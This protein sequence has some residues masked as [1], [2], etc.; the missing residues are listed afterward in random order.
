MLMQIEHKGTPGYSGV[1]YV[2]YPYLLTCDYAES[3]AA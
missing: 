1:I 2:S 3:Y